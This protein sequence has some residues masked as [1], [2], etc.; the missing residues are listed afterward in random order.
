MRKGEPEKKNRPDAPGRASTSPTPQRNAT[1]SIWAFVIALGLSSLASGDLTVGLES[2]NHQ[3]AY[4]GWHCSD[5]S[6]CGS[7]GWLQRLLLSLQISLVPRKWYEEARKYHSKK[8]HRNARWVASKVDVIPPQ[9]PRTQNGLRSGR[10]IQVS[11]RQ[12]AAR[13]RVILCKCRRKH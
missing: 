3:P 8:Q 10:C 12:K 9:S 6:F 1:A 11:K 7:V 4:L 13:A 5:T 2:A